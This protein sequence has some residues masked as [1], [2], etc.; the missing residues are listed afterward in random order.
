MTKGCFVHSPSDYSSDRD[1]WMDEVG[2]YISESTLI[3]KELALDSSDQGVL[4]YKSLSPSLKLHVLN[5]LCDEALSTRQV[6]PPELHT[7]MPYL[8]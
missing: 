6:L 3:S 4:E 2:N 1:D 5:L 8:L 7:H